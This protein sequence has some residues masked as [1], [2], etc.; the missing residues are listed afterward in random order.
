MPG[1]IPRSVNH[2]FEKIDEIQSE[3][4]QQDFLVCVS[5]LEIYN[6]MVHDLLGSEVDPQGKA[7]TLPVKEDA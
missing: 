5:Y 6:E 2:I 1:I 7:R 4:A 3:H